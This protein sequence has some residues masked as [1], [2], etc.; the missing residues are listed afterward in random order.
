MIHPVCTE[1]GLVL[2]CGLDLDLPR[3]PLIMPSVI[4]CKYVFFL[5]LS[6]KAVCL[7]L[8]RRI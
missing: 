5:G 6:L 4:V 2:E 3:M 1:L 7:L 8:Q